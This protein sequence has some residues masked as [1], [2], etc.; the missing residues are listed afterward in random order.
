[1][2]LVLNKFTVKVKANHGRRCDYSYIS[3]AYI[4]VMV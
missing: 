4:K 1:M 3:I 2:T